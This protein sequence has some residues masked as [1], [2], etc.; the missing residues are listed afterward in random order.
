MLTTHLAESSDA[1]SQLLRRLQMS[2]F[3]TAAL[4]VIAAFLAHHGG[5]GAVIAL[6]A[7]LALKLTVS[8]TAVPPA[9][10]AKTNYRFTDGGSFQP[11]DIET[12]HRAAKPA[13]V[14]DG[15]TK[16]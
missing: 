12:K 8:L 5:I 3:I 13:I 15:G 9:S 2:I 16:H 6:F 4:L 7:G 10:T 1:S 11:K 14:I